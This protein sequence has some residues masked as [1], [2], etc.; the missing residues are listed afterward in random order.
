MK[1]MLEQPDQL[2][3]ST[4]QSTL[5]PVE[6]ATLN[7]QLPP[8]QALGQPLQ[9]AG[10]HYNFYMF[11]GLGMGMIGG[12]PITTSTASA[13][14]PAMFSLQQSG[15]MNGLLP[16]NELVP[17]G[18][19]AFLHFHCQF[20]KNQAMNSAQQVNPK[21]KHNCC[22]QASS[23]N[24]HR[25]VAAH[26]PVLLA[27]SIVAKWE[28]PEAYQYSRVNNSQHKPITIRIISKDSLLLA[29][30]RRVAIAA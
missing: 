2:K 19:I 7:G 25:P 27:F 13:S 28:E 18:L 17:N 11:N 8:E 3:A 22:I 23:K 24:W 14:M 15:A 5:L 6:Q 10:Q 26:H 16:P 29:K 1:R 9:D 12:L 30:T 21:A 4:V 20:L